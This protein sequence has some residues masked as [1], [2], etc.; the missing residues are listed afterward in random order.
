M[1]LPIKV[2]KNV[3]ILS[4]LIL[5]LRCLLIVFTLGLNN[6]ISVLLVL[7]LIYLTLAIELEVL[8]H[9]LLVCQNLVDCIACVLQMWVPCF[10]ILELLH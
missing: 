8:S 2:F 6:K 9:Y 1:W 5:K 3:F 4:S 10:L 7:R